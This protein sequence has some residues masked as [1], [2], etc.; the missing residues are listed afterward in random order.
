MKNVVGRVILGSAA[1]VGLAVGTAGMAAAG[2]SGGRQV[3]QNAPSWTH[4]T[5]R[6]GAPAAATRLHMSVV[7]GLKDAAGA[8]ALATAVSDPANAAYG[9]Y[10]SSAQWRSRFAPTDATAKTVSDWLTSQGFSVTGSPANHRFISFDGTAAQANAAFGAQLATYAKGGKSVT[11]PS[12]SVSIPDAIAGLVAG[13]AGLDSSAVAKPTNVGAGDELS[14][15][16]TPSTA[17]A[18]PMASADA[19]AKPADQLP[20]PG[21]VFKNAGPCSAYYGQKAATDVPQILPNPLTYAVCGYTPPQLRGAYGLDTSQTQGVDGRGATVAVVDA[22]ASPTILADATTYAATNDARHPLRSYQF[23]Q[24]LPAGYTHTEECDAS[25][26][27]GE[28]TLDVEAV[29][30]MAPGANILYV[31]GQ[32]CEDNDLAAAVNTVLDNDLAQVITNSY[33]DTGEPASVAD[34]AAS[35]QSALQ[36]AAQ[37]V[38]M[39]FSSGDNGDEVV[40]TGSRQVDYEASDPFVTAVGGT[41]LNVTAS[42]GYGWEQGWG[43]GKSTLTNGSWVPNPPAYVYGGGG[44]TSQLFKQ[45][46]YQKNVV[47]ARIANYFGQG[48]HRAVPDV[49]M[50]GDP[51]TG[52][53]VGQTQQFPNGSF[54]YSEYRIGGTS[55][56]SPLFAGV[57]AVGMQVKGGSLGFLNPRMYKLSGTAAFRDV[58]HSRTVTDGV[59]RVDFANGV[60]ANK[61]KITSLR[62]INQTGSIYVTKGYD[63][64][65]GVGSPNGVSFLLAMA[66]QAST[67]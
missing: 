3:L 59:V 53:L 18:A 5:A 49:G 65:T 8:E 52:F 63:D 23:S 41:S 9:K 61:G 46:A 7:L 47:P 56:S 10:L 26:W 66:G 33:G 43:T 62:T 28:E 19:T 57:V 39:L 36:A 11:A 42:N 4:S 40:N 25:G 15:S 54:K 50:V 55:L 32:S 38:S 20:P 14:T 24:N 64:V 45:P 1:C 31:G 34:V 58:D 60:N 27:Y 44:G 48:A 35:H 12:A 30:A 17:K 29:H 13:V 67:H 22:Y 51:S 37:G 2:S 16:A 6:A 21:A